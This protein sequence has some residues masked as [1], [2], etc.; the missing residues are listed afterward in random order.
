M[1]VERSLRTSV[2]PTRLKAY[3]TV[4]ALSVQSAA[5]VTIVCTHLGGS[6]PPLGR[7]RA[8]PVADS[9][10]SRGRLMAVTAFQAAVAIARRPPHTIGNAVNNRQLL[11]DDHLDSTIGNPSKSFVPHGHLHLSS[12]SPLHTAAAYIAV[13]AFHILRRRILAV[14][15]LLNR[16][17]SRPRGAFI[18]VIRP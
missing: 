9:R 13:Q 16:R 10:S 6:K 3:E 2:S 14:V 5:V 4:G 1:S 15:Y 18:K 17:V 7:Y 8:T 11:D 12:P